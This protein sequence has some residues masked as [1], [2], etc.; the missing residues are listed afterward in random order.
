MDDEYEG[1]ESDS[2]LRRRGWR[3][4]A[5]FTAVV[6]AMS[7][8]FWL[9]GRTDGRMLPTGLPLSALMFVVPG[10]AAALLG[11]PGRSNPARRH[12]GWP[13]SRR[14]WLVTTCLMPA[15]YA[16]AWAL[17]LLAPVVAFHA[18]INLGLIPRS[19]DFYSPAPVAALLLPI[20]W[21]SAVRADAQRRC[22]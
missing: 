4:L 8:P 14:W 13:G 20:A 6:L 18:S 12:A 21:W 7:I 15:T 11:P 9:L 17:P 5:R 19:P 22:E 2:V 16:V 1:H 3:L 10:A